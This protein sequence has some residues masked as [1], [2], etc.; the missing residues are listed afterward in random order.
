MISYIDERIILEKTDNSFENFGVFNPACIKV[1]NITYMFYRAVNQDKISS[2]G[3]CELHNNKVVK[4][5]N[6][7]I[8]YPEFDYEIR[9]LED[10]KITF[11]DGTYYLFYTAYDGSNTSIAYAISTHLPHFIKKGLITPRIPYL[12][13]KQLMKLSGV[14]DQYHI[15]GQDRLLEEKNATLFPKK[16][17][18]KFAV[19]HRILPDLQVIY[20]NN[21]FDLTNDYWKQYL[22]S[23]KNYIVLE[24]K[25]GFENADLG[26]GCPPVETDLGWLLI[27][28]SIEKNNDLKTY[29]ACAALL[30]KND[31]TKVISRLSQPLFSPQQPWE[32]L[33]NINNVVF[34]TSAIVEDDRLL[35]Y[36]GAADKIIAMKEYSLKKLLGLLTLNIMNNQQ[37]LPVKSVII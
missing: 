11:I 23:L 10:P 33:G 27:Y 28:H 13:A 26:G 29:H 18:G 25:Y 3:Y 37:D 14:K 8:L 19:L 30:N 12:E 7:P 34:P 9:G 16:I 1:G 35:I 2:I 36:Y 32:K 6:K 21:F 15:Y 31:P 5:L 24:P 20:F 22:K 4:R 17:N